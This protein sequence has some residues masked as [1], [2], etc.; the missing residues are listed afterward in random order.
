M[1]I[2]VK[3]FQEYTEP[4]GGEE[5]APQ[6]RTEDEES[7]LLPLGDSTLTHNLGIPVVV[8]CTK[9]YNNTHTHPQCRL[10]T[11]AYVC[12]CR[13]SNVCNINIVLRKVCNV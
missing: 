8:V 7:V 1:F 9:V 10:I 12:G 11:I 13:Q 2:V 5:G 3:Q 6:R 4:G